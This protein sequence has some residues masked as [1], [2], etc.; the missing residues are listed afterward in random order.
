MSLRSR[1][2]LAA[3]VLLGV[4]AVMS[5]ILVTTVAHS[6]VAQ[7]D[8]QLRSSF[9]FTRTIPSGHT[10]PE[11]PPLHRAFSASHVGAF[12][13]ASIAAGHR[14]VLSTPLGVASA[15]PELPPMKTT[16]PR[17]PVIAT[18]GSLSGTIT[19]RAILLRAVANRGEILIAIPMN[20]VAST[21]A[22]LRFGL[23]V[24]GL[25]I[26][27]VL[28]AVGIWIVRLGLRPID[29]V[30]E[31][32]S[33]IASGDR[34]RRVRPQR[35]GTE[36]ARLSDAVNTMLD[37]QLELESRLR[38]FVADA[39][40]ELRSPVSVIQGVTELWRVGELREGPA[41][42]EAMRRVG[43]A[44]HQMSRLVEELLLLARL[45]EG[46]GITVS[47]VN[48]SRLVADVVS[49][50]R[51]SRPDRV[52]RV[53]PGHDVAVNADE[54]A[55]RRVLDNLVTNAVRHTPSSTLV[56]VS[57]IE[58]D[59]DVELVVDDTGPGMTTE[60][61]AL[62]FDRFWQADLSRSAVGSGLGLA[63]VRGLVE[64]HGGAVKIH[65]RPGEG[66]TVR[67]IVPRGVGPRDVG[68]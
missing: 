18:V 47:S 21:L 46:Q 16:S 2:V 26:L 29:D 13:I 54:G 62:A 9:P 17:N 34:S 63:I 59:D 20:H 49:Q 28:G 4:L 23:L 40:H 51:E 24:V 11:P 41:A 52:I 15:V 58:H 42:D 65:S 39:S 38:Q 12:Y 7:L 8:G 45:D 10:P 43:R 57:V 27:V 35:A 48:L 67:V 19:W 3:A 55:L 14:T 44:S 30:T 68:A 32:A 64:A 50:V 31:I 60:E 5:A 37:E 53:D 1:L 36:A 22:A 33:A 6:E 66:T 61:V 56:Q 25:V